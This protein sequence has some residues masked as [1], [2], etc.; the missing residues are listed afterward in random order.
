MPV[1]GSSSRV[2]APGSNTKVAGRLAGYW[3]GSTAPLA[4]LAPTGAQ[5]TSNVAPAHPP[6]HLVQLL[7]AV[8]NALYRLVQDDLGLIQVALNLGEL[9]SRLGVL[10][11]WAGG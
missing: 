5:I 8:Q 6:T 2:H 11:R 4:R 7:A 10:L 1:R 3:Q 9:V